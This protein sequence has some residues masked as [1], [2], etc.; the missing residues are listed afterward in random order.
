[1]GE[2]WFSDEDL[3]AM[4]RPTM[5][6]AI[7]AID[8]GIGADDLDLEAGHAELADLLDRRGDAVHRADPVGNQRD[9]RSLA[10]TR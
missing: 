8:A 5:D 9:P 7:E 10:R 2:R 6:R 4:S 1:M 3:K